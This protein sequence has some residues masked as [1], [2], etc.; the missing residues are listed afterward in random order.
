MLTK[1]L[2]FAPLALALTAIG[3]AAHVDDAAPESADD[4]DELTSN[5][6]RSRSLAFDGAVYVRVDASDAEILQAVQRQTKTAFGALRTAQIGVNNRELKAV[7]P[8]TFVKSVVEVV[9]TPGTPGTAMTKVTYRY[10]DDAVVPVSMARRT[11]ISLAV[12]GQ[13]YESKTDRILVECTDN[14][15]EAHDFRGS[16]W[17]VFNASTSACKK[18]I[19]AESKVVEADRAKLVDPKTQV[20]ASEV[21]RLY[22]PMTVRLG[23]DKTNKGRSYPEYDRLYAGGVQKGKLVMGVVNGVIDHGGGALVDDSGYH[24]WMNTMREVFRARPGYKLVKSEPQETFTFKVGQKTLSPTIQQ[25]VDWE[26]DGA[27][28]AGLSQTDRA[29]LRKQ[30]GDKLIKHWLTIE[31]ETTVQIGDAPAQPLTLQLFTYFGAESSE[32]PHKRAIK[33]S[34]VFVYNGHSYIGFGPLDPSRFSVGDFPDSYQLLFIDGCVSYNYYEKD[35]FPLKAGGTK[36]LDLVTN[37]MEA[38]AWQSGW[39]LGRFLARLTDGTQA[40]YRDLLQA[41]S[42]TDPL[43]VVDGEVDNAYSPTKTPI[44]LK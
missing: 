32:V 16:L 27:W 42:A 26:L 17:Y 24:D 15:E 1:S 25:M 21:S 9:T 7:D 4:G 3:C 41:A 38:P 33:N 2:R 12:L 22:R 36:N 39:A 28:P 11:A 30:V 10:T 40:S 19:S 5:T 44:K 8:K 13:G 31:A 35:Y 14:D 20:P 43:R 37:G 23:A 29:S 18:A 6:A 34:D